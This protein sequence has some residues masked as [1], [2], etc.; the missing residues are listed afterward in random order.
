MVFTKPKYEA[1]LIAKNSLKQDDGKIHK[2]VFI[3]EE[4]QQM[5]KN[6]LE[7]FDWYLRK[8]LTGQIARALLR[9]LF[10]FTF[11]VL[12]FLT[13]QE[14]NNCIESIHKIER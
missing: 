4:I 13:H 10:P 12:Y 11:I 2:D 9:Y 1:I 14:Y 3:E 7:I 6:Q 5:E 8:E